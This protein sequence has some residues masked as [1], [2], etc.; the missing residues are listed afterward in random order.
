[1]SP[2]PKPSVPVVEEE[3]G[4]GHTPGPWEI[5][6][7]GNG[8]LDPLTVRVAFTSGAYVAEIRPAGSDDPTEV[9]ANAHLISAA[10]DLLAA[11]QMALRE[12]QASGLWADHPNC[13]QIRAAITKAHGDPV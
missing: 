13:E 12:L 6:S 8:A 4:V 9:R 2:T 1:M 11:C 7:R 10:P 3:G 5:V